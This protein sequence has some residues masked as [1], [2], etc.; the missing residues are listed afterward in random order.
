[1]K[2]NLLISEFSDANSGHV[3]ALAQL[4]FVILYLQLSTTKQ[5]FTKRQH[6]VR[7]L[8]FL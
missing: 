8:T 6:G 5:T 1:M 3:F 7:K 4:L 2:T